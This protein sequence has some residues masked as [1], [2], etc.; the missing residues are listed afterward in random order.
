[1][2]INKSTNSITSNHKISQNIHKEKTGS[3]RNHHP[4]TTDNSSSS[5]NS[6]SNRDSNSN[7]SNSNNTND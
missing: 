2:E 4:T 1:M 6:N 3:R 7:S 5:S